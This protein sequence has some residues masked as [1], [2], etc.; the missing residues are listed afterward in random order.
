MKKNSIAL[1]VAFCYSVLSYGQEQAVMGAA[2]VEASNIA[3]QVSFTIG[4]MVVE[5]AQTPNNIVTQGYHQSAL[6]VTAIGDPIADL[7]L[8]V[9][10]NPTSDWVI[11][12]SSKLQNIV[13]VSLYDM[14]GSLVQSYRNNQTNQLTIDMSNISAGTYLLV[15]ESTLKNQSQTFQIIKS[16]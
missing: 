8:L 14:T 16:H 6:V 11:L 4:E 15:A 12:E 2:G 10:P 5:T 3:G 7:N 1:I 9:Y 13:S